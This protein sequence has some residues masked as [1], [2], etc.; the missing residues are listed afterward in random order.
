[1]SLLSLIQ[2]EIA[3]ARQ[4]QIDI[5]GISMNPVTFKQYCRELEDMLLQNAITQFAHTD[6]LQSATAYIRSDELAL[7]A[8]TGE[9]FG[10]I[11]VAVNIPVVDGI[12][13][14]LLTE[15]ARPDIVVNAKALQS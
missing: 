6:T 10:N 4:Q 2:D 9:I 1:M 11:P 8:V 14:I 7:K 3:I 5:H 13:C 12:S 15:Y